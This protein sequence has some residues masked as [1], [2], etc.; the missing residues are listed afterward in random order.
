MN[1][2][3]NPECIAFSMGFYEKKTNH[4]L[5]GCGQC[6]CSSRW[7]SC[8]RVAARRSGA[9]DVSPKRGQES[10]QSLVLDVY[11]LVNQHNYGQS[12]FLM[13]KLTINGHVQ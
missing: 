11:P 4:V 7:R 5:G 2:W 6:C 10:C 13:G 3:L 8:L 12:P 1:S 9:S